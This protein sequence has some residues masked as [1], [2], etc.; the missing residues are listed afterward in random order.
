MKIGIVTVFDAVNYG[1]FLQAYCLQEI[2]KEMGHDVFMIKTSSLLYEKWRF[3]SLFTYNPKK[4][5]FKNKLAKGYFESWKKFNVIHNS[6]N[7]KL[8]LL[9]IGSDEMW[10]L[11]NITM[12]PRPEF[13]G[14]GI[15]AKHKV[16]YAVSC[17]STKAD[18]IKQSQYAAKAV[19]KLDFVSVRDQATFEA[20]RDFL[21]ENPVFSVD[22]T[23]L[24]KLEDYAIP[25]SRKNYILCYTYTFKPY[26]IEAA[27]NLANK[28]GKKLIVVGQNFSWADEAVPATAFE[29]L[30]LIKGADF[31]IT[32]TFH[33][34]TL[35]IGLKKQFAAFA[36][37]TKVYKAL[38]LFNL[39]D[40]NI[41]GEKDISKWYD[42]K[43]DY[44]NAYKNVITPLI[45]DSFDY[46]NKVT[47]LG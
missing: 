42:E 5:A 45:Q 28:L 3:T 34:T 25:T 24:V 14:V 41:N 39:L 47:N 35:S 2:L 26:M 22:P 44:E 30:G 31:I 36:Y 32:D 18:D 4:F 7:K 23:L 29:F 16:T 27:R 1:S 12:K 15:D 8:D 38:E 46:L 37:K 21:K 20:Y 17:N 13:F 11:K 33:G 40:R 9:I 43:I 6:K 10:E 19:S